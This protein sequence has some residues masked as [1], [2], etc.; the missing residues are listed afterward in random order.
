MRYDPTKSMFYGTPATTLQTWLTNAQQAY[1]ALVT[2][3][4][5]VSVS[6]DGKAVTYTQANV[7]DLRELIEEFQ[8]LLGVKHVRRAIRLRFR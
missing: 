8:A 5:P 6:Y 7:A 1:V 2:G 4:K 3:G